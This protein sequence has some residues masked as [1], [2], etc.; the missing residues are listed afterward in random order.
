MRRMTT[1][2]AICRAEAL[3]HMGEIR[4][5]LEICAAQAESKLLRRAR[6]K[7]AGEFF[8]PQEVHR[9]VASLKGGVA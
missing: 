1:R 3:K 8:G 5:A 7:A 6:Q 9:A 4:E 2:E